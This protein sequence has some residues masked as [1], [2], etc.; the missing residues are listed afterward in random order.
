MPAP[1]PGRSRAQAVAWAALVL[2]AAPAA[3]WT[4]ARHVQPVPSLPWP[5]LVWRLGLYAVLEELAFRGAIHPWLAQ[6]R[7]LAGRGWGGLSAA[8]WLTSA[9]FAAVHATVQP[10]WQAAAMGPVSL[11][12]GASLDQSRRLTVPV[13]LHLYFNLL[14]WLASLLSTTLPR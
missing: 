12:L 11:V 10:P 5:E 4:W 3:A 2:V 13:G 14:L 9:A 1:G 8:N 7:S 6:R